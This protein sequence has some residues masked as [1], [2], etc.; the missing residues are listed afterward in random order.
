MNQENPNQNINDDLAFNDHNNLNIMTDSIGVD[1]INSDLHSAIPSVLPNNNPHDSSS[2]SLLTTQP[3][4][5]HQNQLIEY[6]NTNHFKI[7]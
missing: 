3:D 6:N 4:S 2:I 5:N 1:D 7:Y